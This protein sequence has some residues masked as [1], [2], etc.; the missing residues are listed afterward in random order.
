MCIMGS[1][2]GVIFF[3]PK[4]SLAM[5][6]RITRYSYDHCRK[7]DSREWESVVTAQLPLTLALSH[8]VGPHI[9]RECLRT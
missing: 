1:L 5:G 3:G 8:H 4:L 2:Q 7:L 9:N 6:R